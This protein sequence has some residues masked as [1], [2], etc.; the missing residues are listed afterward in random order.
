MAAAEHAAE[1]LKKV[2]G[3]PVRPFTMSQALTHK[4]DVFER[5]VELSGDLYVHSAAAMLAREAHPDKAH[6]LN[7]PLPANLAQLAFRTLKKTVYMNTPGLGI[8]TTQD[9]NAAFRFDE[10]AIAELVTNPIDNFK[11]LP[12]IMRFHGLVEADTL[13]MEGVQTDVTYTDDDFY[14]TPTWAE[15]ASAVRSGV[16]VYELPGQHDEV[17]LNPVE[18]FE[19]YFAAAE[20]TR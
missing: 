10:S 20:A 5:A 9:K 19:N 15:K 7:P 13:H 12:R 4:R 16:P 14:Y 11:L 17:I 3:T 8:H 1:G 18:F 2:T 6:F